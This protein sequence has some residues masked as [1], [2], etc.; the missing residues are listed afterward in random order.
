MTITT[1]AIILSLGSAVFGVLLRYAFEV[2][3]EKYRFKRELEDNN[4]IDVTGDDW[5]AAWQTA[6]EKQVLVNTEKLCMRQKGKVVKVWNTEKS[7]ENPK[8]GYRWESQLQFFQGRV[9]MGWYFPLKAENITSKGIM[10]LCYH[11]AK[12]TFYGKWVGS[13]YDGDL[14]NG[15]MVISK[16]RSTSRSELDKLMTAHPDKVNVIF[17]SI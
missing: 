12:K 1:S 3:R 4:F 13:A 10:F 11:S 7:P 5:H 17:D 15:F 6:V 14:A 16:D 2:A 9:L 8:G